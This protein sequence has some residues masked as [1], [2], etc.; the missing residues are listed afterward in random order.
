MDEQRELIIEKLIEKFNKKRYEY[1]DICKTEFKKYQSEPNNK[2]LLRCL[3]KK[4]IHLRRMGRLTKRSKINNAQAYIYELL[5]SKFF[6]DVFS[7]EEK[8]DIYEYCINKI[9]GLYK[10]AQALKTGFCNLQII[11]GF[12]EHNTISVCLTKNTLEAN[13]QWLTR[14][15]NELDNRFP[16]V[17]LNDKIIIISSKKNTLNGNATHCKDLNTAWRYLKRENNFK[18]IFVCSNKTRISD[19]LEMTEDFM[20]LNDNLRKK[21]RILHDEAHNETE[22]IPPY[23]SIIENIICQPNILSYEPVTASLGVIKDDN[24][25][26]WTKSNL[27][28][29]AI[30]F[31]EFDNTKSND[32]SYSSC[33]DNIKIY[34]EDIKSNEKWVDY[35]ITEVSPELFK[36][37]HGTNFSDYDIERKRKL[38]FCSFMKFTKEIEAM[39]NGLNCI[40]LNDIIG[41]DYFIKNEFNLHIISTPKRN[42]ITRYIAEEAIKMDYNPI[43]LAIYGGHGSKYNL[44]YDNNELEVSDIM[45]DGEFNSKLNKL[46]EYLKKESININRPFIIIGNYSPT[47][48][49]LSYVNYTYGT[50]RGNIRLISTN[51]EQD[52][53]QACRSNYMNT[54][55][56]KEICNWTNP[57]KYLVG[58]RKYIDNA[59]SYEKENDARID[60]LYSNNLSNNNISIV[61]HIP[62]NIIQSEGIIATPIKITMDREEPQIIEL[63]SIALK[64]R[65]TDDDKER[66]KILLKECCENPDI[67]CNIEDQNGKFNFDYFK[68]GDFRT[69]KKKPTE[70]KKGVWKFKNYKA[71]FQ[72]NTPFMNDKNNHTQNQFEIL[73]C[74]DRYIIKENGNVIEENSRS[75]WWI[76]YK[77]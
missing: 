31:T 42:I 36:K 70:T 38:D 71:H 22:G 35:G 57:K 66:F 32:Q 29:N 48:E 33:S 56:K 59:L 62:Q 49:S 50:V 73:I 68:L 60:A 34:F 77:Y 27:E 23:R 8:Y 44:F 1:Y 75:I 25:Q 54:K 19:I 4:Y 15:F 5:D 52:Y 17:K 45:G 43:V 63:L 67:D 14:L 2:D 58:E 11:T 74:Y 3:S 46:I 40:R 18:I 12:S 9:R 55:F 53:Q 30:N 28:I 65:K 10:H 24:N 72:S 47:G 20:N 76:G 39:N 26:L 69:Y 37:V 61:Q 41:F 16:Q 21:L 7:Q 51:A 13:N 6:K 64:V